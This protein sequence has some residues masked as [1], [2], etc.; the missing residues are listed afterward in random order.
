MTGHTASR[1]RVDLE[2]F[3]GETR[4]AEYEDFNV[5]D[6]S[7]EF[8]LIIGKVYCLLGKHLIGRVYCLL[9]KL[10]IYSY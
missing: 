9:I 4:Y 8:K 1:L 3:R 6:E 10:I 2:D 7:Q 5:L